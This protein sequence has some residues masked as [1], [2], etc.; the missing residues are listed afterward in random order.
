MAILWTLALLSPPVVALAIWLVPALRPSL[1]TAGAQSARWGTGL[2]A[3]VFVT[4]YF[5]PMIFMPDSNLGPILGIFAAPPAF[6][7]G[8]IIHSAVAYARGEQRSEAARSEGTP[9]DE[10]RSE[11]ASATRSGRDGA[12]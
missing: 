11:E 7:L 1:L 2:A 8:T 5:G 4:G 3:G 10:A 9:S 6:L 12:Q